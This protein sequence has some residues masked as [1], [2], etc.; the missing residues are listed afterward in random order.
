MA[1]PEAASAQQHPV[2]TGGDG[3]TPNQRAMLRMQKTAG[4][5]A[6]RRRLNSGIVQRD[7]PEIEAVLNGVIELER[8]ATDY[9]TQ[10]CDWTQANYTRFLEFSS[11]TGAL[12]WGNTEF[13][14][15]V[16]ELLGSG[17]EQ[18]VEFVAGRAAEAVVDVLFPEAGGFA[19]WLARQA[20][21]KA[22][23]WL[24][25]HAGES[26]QN[27]FL[28][29]QGHNTEENRNTA[30][31]ATMGRD[32]R[33]RNATLQTER[34]QGINEI[35]ARLDRARGRIRGA[36]DS[37]SLQNESA[38]VNYE[39][40]AV[41]NRLARINVQDLTLAQRMIRA[42][43]RENAA[44]PDEARSN[45]N[46]ADW[47]RAVNYGFPGEGGNLRNH[48]EMFAH[49]TRGHWS[50]AGLAASG[51]ATGLIN[52]VQ[53]YHNDTNAIFQSFNRRQF[54]FNAAENVVAC[55]QFLNHFQ[56]REQVVSSYQAPLEGQSSR[57]PA[58]LEEYIRSLVVR[59]EFNLTCQMQLD[60]QE[61]SVVAT[62]W[63]YSL[64]PLRG[65]ILAQDRRINPSRRTLG[66]PV[67]AS[68]GI[69]SPFST[70]QPSAAVHPLQG[71]QEIHEVVPQQRSI[72]VL[73][74]GEIRGQ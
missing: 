5:A 11:G 58:T 45:V 19:G 70:P 47:T 25:G 50:R 49:Q 12:A 6:V 31:R 59:G 7:A 14:Q 48:P 15:T 20:T 3:L 60:I 22:V 74:S 42:W 53:N 39:L 32:I 4:N 44:G 34:T 33:A 67:A 10:V 18:A 29:S 63:T 51:V 28:T 71:V 56:F 43:S 57:L 41:Q 65:Q 2:Y 16:G 62:S 46:Q 69:L 26:A 40:T 37:A 17:T 23:G 38:S 36:T 66:T 24:A 1:S 64:A 68:S 13:G 54:T 21:E 61:G 30:L 52:S 55:I 9:Y 8:T 35:R 27:S 73:S 72:A